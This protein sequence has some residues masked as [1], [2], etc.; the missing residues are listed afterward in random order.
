MIF[1]LGFL[2]G[3]AVLILVA[4]YLAA[5]GAKPEQAKQQSGFTATSVSTNGNA[6]YSLEDELRI[7]RNGQTQI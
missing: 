3:A 7:L 2:C 1:V 4:L 6:A 5:K